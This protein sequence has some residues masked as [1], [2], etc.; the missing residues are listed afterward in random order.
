MLSYEGFGF[1]C[2]TK[3]SRLVPNIHRIIIMIIGLFERRCWVLALAAER[4]SLPGAGVPSRNDLSLAPHK[5]RQARALY[6]RY[7]V[8]TGISSHFW[9]QSQALFSIVLSI[10]FK[11]SSDPPPPDL[12][13]IF[14]WAFQ[15]NFS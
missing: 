3:W 11:G 4:L 2:V 1:S 8:G 15:T 14:R 13:K 12:A 9:R 10:C 6:R 7:E 5:I